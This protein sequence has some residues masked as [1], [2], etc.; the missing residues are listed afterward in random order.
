MFT[1]M[2]TSPHGML[3]YPFVDFVG[4]IYTSAETT[5]PDRPR[6]YNRKPYPEPQMQSLLVDFGA[7]DCITTVCA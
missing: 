6:P 3:T 5:S 2:L 4:G 7:K 1:K